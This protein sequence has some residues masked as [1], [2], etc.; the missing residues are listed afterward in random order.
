MLL[1][2]LLFLQ[3]DKLSA[4][5]PSQWLFLLPYPWPRKLLF[6]LQVSGLSQRKPPTT[7]EIQ[8]ALFFIVHL[9]L[10][11]FPSKHSLPFV[12]T[13]IYLCGYLKYVSP[14]ILK[15]LCVYPIIPSL[16]H[17]AQK[18]VCS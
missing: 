9:T 17:F 10:H 4:S 18:I 2:A 1:T 3:D 7:L 14:I 13:Y 8:S 16:W 15:A 12:I 5:S 11:F 6:I